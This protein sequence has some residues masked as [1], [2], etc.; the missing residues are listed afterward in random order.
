[1]FNPVG[2][3]VMEVASSKAK[4]DFMYFMQE[5][6]KDFFFIGV[7][8]SLCIFDLRKYPFSGNN[9]IFFT[10]ISSQGFF[11]QMGAFFT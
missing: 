8:F 7:P 1:M 6:Y 4:I 11:D 2:S 5:K 10:T 3:N 9:H